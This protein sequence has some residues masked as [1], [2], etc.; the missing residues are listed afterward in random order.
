MGKKLGDEKWGK[1]KWGENNKRERLVEGENDRNFD[2]GSKV[3]SLGPPLG[4]I[5]ESPSTWREN[6]GERGA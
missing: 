1:E 4:L 6:E 2:G 3:F 5:L